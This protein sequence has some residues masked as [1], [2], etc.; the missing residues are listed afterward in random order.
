MTIDAALFAL[1]ES[2]V[3]KRCYPDITP[4]GADFPLI[5]YQ[6]VGGE[7]QEFLERR[8]PD[9]ENYRVQVHCWAKTRLQVSALALQVREQIIEHGTAFATAKTLGQRVALYDEKLKLYGTRQDF[10]IWIKER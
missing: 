7:S 10:G 6:T 1:L 4:P 5:V 9:C 8:L 3:S 2:L